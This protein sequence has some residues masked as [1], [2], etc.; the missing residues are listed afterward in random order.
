MLTPK[1][2]LGLHAVGGPGVEWGADAVRAD[3][4][5]A[6]ERAKPHE[7]HA[8]R[9][10]DWVGL[11]V[12]EQAGE[13]I[14]ARRRVP[15]RKKGAFLKLLAKKGRQAREDEPVLFRECPVP[16]D[17]HHAPEADAV[18]HDRLSQGVEPV[19]GVVTQ[20]RPAGARELLVDARLDDVADAL[21]EDGVVL[22]ELAPCHLGKRRLV[23]FFEFEPGAGGVSVGR[24][25][26]EHGV[27]EHVGGDLHEA[28]EPVV[29][30]KRLEQALAGVGYISGVLWHRRFPFPFA[31]R[32]P[33]ARTH[34]SMVFDS[35]AM[36]E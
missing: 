33:R 31:R 35:E 8:P 30:K 25:G 1:C 32:L 12:V 36:V 24:V 10:R 17:H 34:G 11:L 6:A 28:L 14:R 23:V 26:D 21:V 2:E 13:E 18:D 19:D 3:D 5:E 7:L 20:D 22:G 9:A 27:S 16:G 4:K 15:D 29:G